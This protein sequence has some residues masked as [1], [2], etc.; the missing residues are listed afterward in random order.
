MS[1]NESIKSKLLDVYDELGTD[2]AELE[3]F[4]ALLGEP[5][6]D[7]D[8]HV[9]PGLMSLLE[10]I[11]GEIKEKHLVIGEIQAELHEGGEI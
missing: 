5:S 4:A 8:R 1:Q 10:R 6:N 11:H 2:L 9:R 7:I 3:A